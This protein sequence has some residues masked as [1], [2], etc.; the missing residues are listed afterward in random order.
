MNPTCDHKNDHD[1]KDDEEAAYLL[2]LRSA[3][4]YANVGWK[5]KTCS[6]LICASE[7]AAAFERRIYLKCT[8]QKQQSYCLTAYGIHQLYFLRHLAFPEAILRNLKLQQHRAVRALHIRG[9]SGGEPSGRNWNVGSCTD[10][11]QWTSSTWLKLEVTT[12][13]CLLNTNLII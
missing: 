8:A 11:H 2:L 3:T 7:V 5:S 1:P 4:F 6:E 9:F 13:T 12:L 10:G